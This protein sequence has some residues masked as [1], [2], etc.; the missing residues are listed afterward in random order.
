M[1]TDETD[2]KPPLSRRRLLTAGMIAAT[3]TGAGVTLG[4]GAISG[5]P[6]LLFDDADGEGNDGSANSAATPESQPPTFSDV[7]A[8]DPWNGLLFLAGK[9]PGY[10]GA[11]LDSLMG[12]SPA[13]ILE[14]CDTV[15]IDALEARRGE[16]GVARFYD[17]IAEQALLSLL[18]G[19]G[20]KPLLLALDAGH[21]GLRGVFFDPGSNG[22]EYYHVRR[23]AEAIEARVA[24]PR[25]A[26]I[27]LRRLYNDAIGDDF[28]LPPPQDRKSAA[29]LTIRNIRGAMLAWEVDAW[30][31]RHPD[32]AVL[33]HVLSVHFNAGAG[34]ILVLHQGDAVP[35][36][37]RDRS[38]QFARAY[39]GRAHAAIAQTGLLPPQGFALG[40][41]LSDDRILYDAMGSGS[42]SPINPYTGV[43]R[44]TLPRRYAMLQ[45]SLS[46]RDYA[47]GALRYHKLV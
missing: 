43:N 25:F 21:G 20:D 10:P 40:D 45:A 3:L 22:T 23:V 33:L 6:L 41:G 47:D 37:F 19:Y 18:D 32:K 34:G 4:K 42:L 16:A 17:V 26:S 12:F 38:Y 29:S 2:A 5:R 30:N 35:A 7:A 11:N 9:L 13:D 46:E 28:F 44:S 31:R 36:P 8:V 24:E 1:T 15:E 39:V 14:T 27:T